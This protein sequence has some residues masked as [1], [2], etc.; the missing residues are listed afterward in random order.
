MVWFNKKEEEKEIDDFSNKKVN[1]IK[2]YYSNLKIETINKKTYGW[3]IP[4]DE[5]KNYKKPWINFYQWYFNRPQS[6]HYI[7]KFNKGERMIRRED[8]VS[9]QILVEEKIIE[10]DCDPPDIE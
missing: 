9:F 3:E 7:M 10:T 2:K 5:H 4:I 8:I 6:K 1:Y